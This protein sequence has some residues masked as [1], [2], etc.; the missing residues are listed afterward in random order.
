MSFFSLFIKFQSSLDNMFKFREAI[1]AGRWAW[2]G[3][4]SVMRE[5]N[6]HIRLC[7]PDRA[8]AQHLLGCVWA[9]LCE[10][11]ESKA[12]TTHYTADEAICEKFP[13]SRRYFAPP[14]LL[15]LQIYPLVKHSLASC[16]STIMYAWSNYIKHISFLPVFSSAWTVI[17]CLGKSFIG[18]YMVY[19][20]ISY[21]CC[22]NWVTTFLNRID[23]N[24][25][26]LC[27]QSQK[28][29]II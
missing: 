18:V 14:W 16:Q 28:N 19:I 8:Q 5:I 29:M 13:E 20:L 3:V 21:N 25:V 9:K 23:Q 26:Y 1:F 12:L 2:Q 7:L 22:C 24:R 15:A 17:I 27:R 10:G 6:A 11:L 4:G